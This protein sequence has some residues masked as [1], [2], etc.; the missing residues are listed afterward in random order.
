MDGERQQA[1]SV[2]MTEDK[3]A[4]PDPSPSLS[5]SEDGGSNAENQQAESLKRKRP[6]TTAYVKLYCIDLIDPFAHSLP[7]AFFA[8]CGLHFERRELD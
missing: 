8:L 7:T 6:S 1:S 3:N 4:A 2:Y 5:A